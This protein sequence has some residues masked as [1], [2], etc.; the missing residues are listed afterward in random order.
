MAHKVIERLLYQRRRLKVSGGI[1]TI[2]LEKNL[3]VHVKKVELGPSKEFVGEVLSVKTTPGSLARLKDEIE[4]EFGSR[5]VQVTADAKPYDD[6][7][8]GG[9]GMALKKLI[10]RLEEG[11]KFMSIEPE[12]FTAYGNWRDSKA[13]QAI[14]DALLN[15]PHWYKGN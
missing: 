9:E 10:L 11:R 6:L 8:T 7:L 14:V 4:Q 3:P 2:R 1:P 12:R 15:K 5:G 13:A